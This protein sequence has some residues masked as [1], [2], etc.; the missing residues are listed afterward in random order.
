[1]GAGGTQRGPSAPKKRG[2][3]G[4]QRTQASEVEQ[5]SYTERGSVSLSG[6]TGQYLGSI[7]AWE[8]SSATATQTLEKTP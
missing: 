6:Q 1:M 7:I 4:T 5:V 8:A 2:F 3:R